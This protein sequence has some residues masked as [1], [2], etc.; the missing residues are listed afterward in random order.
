MK[1]QQKMWMLFLIASSTS[2]QAQVTIGADDDP[3]NAKEFA[4]LRL[5]STTGGLR[6]PQLSSTQITT[7]NG[8]MGSSTLAPGLMVF[9][10]DGTG[11]LQ[12]YVG[13][14]KWV[15]LS[16]IRGVA[17][18]STEESVQFEGDAVINI[19]DLESNNYVKEYSIQS[20]ANQNIELIKAGKYLDYENIV[21]NIT[22]NPNS[23][24]SHKIGVEFYPKIKDLLHTSGKAGTISVR[25]YAKYIE[26]G[27]EKQIDFIVR[28]TNAE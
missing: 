5:V 18:S 7:L 21:K 25:L 16:A 22:F 15:N 27:I 1:L 10:T 20:L 23:S 2:L 13:N 24:A 12:Y 8:V 17:K 28:I 6:Y 9:N 3:N 26:G 19:S 14:N 11:S 4:A